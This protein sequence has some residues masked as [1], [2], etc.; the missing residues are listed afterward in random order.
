MKK[1]KNITKGK[2]GSIMMEYFVLLVVGLLILGGFLLFLDS[3][4]MFAENSLKQI[5][6]LEKTSDATATLGKF[7]RI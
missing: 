7:R 3:G 6:K 5:G 1:I 2:K 4:S